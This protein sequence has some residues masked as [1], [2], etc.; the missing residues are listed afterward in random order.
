MTDVFIKGLI[1]PKVRF[2][3]FCDLNVRT[4]LIRILVQE[5]LTYSTSEKT[6]VGI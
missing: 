3:I 5:N 2:G 1:T 6:L 4:F